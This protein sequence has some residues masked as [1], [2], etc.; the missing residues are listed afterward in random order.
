MDMQSG[1]TDIYA[2]YASIAKCD[3]LEF[4]YHTITNVETC[5]AEPIIT[6]P[7]QD[8]DLNRADFRRYTPQNGDYGLVQI[9]H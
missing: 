3:T 4:P 1:T 9:L 8:E 7:R 6:V 2:P 5:T